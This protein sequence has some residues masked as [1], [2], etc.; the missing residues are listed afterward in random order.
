M[1]PVRVY[2]YGNCS[3]CKTAEAMIRDAEPTY[4]RR[5]I[6]QQKL[7]PEDIAVLLHEIGRSPREVLSTRSIP[8]RDLRLAEKQVPDRELIELMSV[9]PGLLKRPIIIADKSV[10]IGF[11]RTALN[12]LLENHRKDS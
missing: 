11:N 1:S 2:L 7:S 10:L 6:F 9:Y 3:S 12:S 4:E 5:D 8:Y